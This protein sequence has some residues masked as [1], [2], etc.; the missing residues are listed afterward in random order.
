M[1]RTL[2]APVWVNEEEGRVSRRIFTD[3]VIYEQ[4]VEQIFN[5][6]WLF[7]GHET[8]LPHPGDYVTR[9]M[10]DDQVTVSSNLLLYRSR[11]GREPPYF[12]SAERRDILRRVDDQL[13]IAQ[14]LV[15]LDESVFG[16]RNMSVFF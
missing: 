6:S 12:F 2:D 3:P 9:P 8:E 4:K 11:G 16:T 13:R 7:L 14:R 15:R 10:G 5:R 1:I